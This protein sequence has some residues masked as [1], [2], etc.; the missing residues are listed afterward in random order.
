VRQESVAPF[1][2]R[3]FV[4]HGSRSG[5]AT[6]F[7]PHVGSRRRQVPECWCGLLSYGKDEKASACKKE[8]LH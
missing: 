8:P 1:H 2:V 4:R 5:T 7:P 3:V 6:T